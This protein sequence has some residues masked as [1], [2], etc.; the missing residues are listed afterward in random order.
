MV[1]AD[2]LLSEMLSPYQNFK[3]ALKSKDLQRQYPSL[4]GRFLNF[5]NY[6]EIWKKDV[7][8]IKHWKVEIRY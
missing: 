6:K 4:L 3:Y 5:L 2:F 1:E 8:I 7:N